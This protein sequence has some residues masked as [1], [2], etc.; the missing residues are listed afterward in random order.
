MNSMSGNDSD[1][2]ASNDAVHELLATE[3]EEANNWA[4]LGA[5]LYFGWFTLLLTVNGFATGWLFTRQ[6]PVPR[7][8]R[9]VYVV[10]VVLDLLGAVATF[11]IRRHL[12]ESDRRIREVLEQLKEGLRP[13]IQRISPQS[14]VPVNAI[15]TAFVFTGF[16][17]I[18]LVL[19]WLVLAIFSAQLDH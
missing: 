12:H 15:N 17:L 6:G 2:V 5:Q 3:M 19:F 18:L 10:F 1:S 14:P 7:F 9:L 8:S 11:R 13:A 16:A 4:R